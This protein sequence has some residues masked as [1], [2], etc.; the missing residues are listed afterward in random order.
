MSPTNKTEI[1]RL[2]EKLPNKKSRGH[3][4]I[5]NL[6]LKSLKSSISHP[7]E[8]IFNKSL[9][10]GSFPEM[11]KQADVTPL[12]KSKEKYI[13]NNYRSISLLLTI[14]KILEKTVYTRTYNFLCDSNQLYQSQYG[15]RTEHSCENAICELVGTIAKNR[16]ERKHTIGVF[17]DLSKAFDTLN[18][19]KLLCKMEKYGIRGSNLQ[20]FESYLENR[21]M[22]VKCISN[23]TGQLEYSTY[24]KLEY[25]TPQGSCL[26]PLL[27][28]IY[29]NDLQNSILYSTTILFAD[30]TT[31]LQGHQ[32]L[33]YLKWS[34]EEDLKLMI[35]WFKANL[36]TIN[37]EKTECLLFHRNNS[38]S[39]PNLELE[40]GTHTIK[41]TDQVKFL[42]LWIDTKL[43]WTLHTNTLLMKLKQNTNL[44]KVSNR[45]LN[46]SS[47]KLVYYAHIYSHLTYGL[48]IWGN[49]IDSGT[50]KKLQRSMDICFNLITH[51]P[52]TP[53]NY[54]KESMLNLEELLLIENTKLA[55]KLQHHLLPVRL[56]NMLNSDSRMKS[57]E[58][59]HH[60]ETRNKNIPKL[61]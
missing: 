30:D 18:H 53:S 48:P 40:L 60:Y 43:Q 16:E 31:L 46:K 28:L 11:M 8:I 25:D 14:S 4:N 57:L 19:H 22:R 5:S 42:G 23:I 44:L 47:K 45:F 21:S 9:L 3:D 32:N 6:L 15:F 26:G 56:N 35:D 39:P 37:L 55:F 12:H 51:L 52:P 49:M 34:I 24:H 20:W 1:E 58:K 38:K 41:S 2:I 61:P 13:V 54:K 7:L 27:F 17:I 50:K 29:I 59:R 33:K 36:L 10:E